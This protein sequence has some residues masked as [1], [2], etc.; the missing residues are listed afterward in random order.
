MTE[1]LTVEHEGPQVCWFE[2]LILISE[3]QLQDFSVRKFLVAARETAMV[4]IEKIGISDTTGD[5]NPDTSLFSSVLL[6]TTKFA[7]KT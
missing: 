4:I 5:L 1:R 3:E 7:K 6:Q 2:G